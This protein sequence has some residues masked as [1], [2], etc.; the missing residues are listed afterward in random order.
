ME[1]GPTYS[2]AI[3]A[4]ELGVLMEKRDA[5]AVAHF[6]LHYGAFA[7]TAGL[8]AF[9]DDVRVRIAAAIVC[10]P[11]WAGMFAALHETLHLTAFRTRWLNEIAYWLACFVLFFV[12]T[13]ERELHFEHH[14]HSHEPARDPELSV[15][16]E[17]LARGPR[18]VFTWLFMN[19]GLPLIVARMVML[20]SLAMAM[21]IVL[22]R[23]EG[24]PK[25][26]RMPWIRERHRV[27]S[28]VEA[29]VF[30]AL[31]GVAAYACARAHA[32][33]AVESFVALCAAFFA[34]QAMLAIY[35][36][37]EHRGLEPAGDIFARTRSLQTNAIVRWLAWNMSW[38]AEHHAYPAVPFHALRELHGRLLPRL[39]H[40]ERGIAALTWAAFRRS[41]QMQRR[42]CGSGSSLSR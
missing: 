16:G 19:S 2:D 30:L 8:A 14:R 9:H 6:G 41:L 12:P 13:A 38:H 17:N 4:R 5:P 20:P 3:D 25:L 40:H 11:L 18:N 32:G 10:A 22:A 24:A 1:D 15:D 26:I 39:V 37:C 23:V 21:P 27:R 28:V 36:E 31:Y 42:P 29:W 7:V 34:G 33:L 35:Q